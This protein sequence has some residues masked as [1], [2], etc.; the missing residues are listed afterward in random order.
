MTLLMDIITIAAVFIL[1][2]IIF[3]Y[4]VFPYIIL[5]WI[6]VR[7]GA[8]FT[9]MT[10]KYYSEA[11]QFADDFEDI[12]NLEQP[13]YYFNFDEETMTYFRSEDK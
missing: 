7:L 8:Y 11:V 10:L 2:W 13:L 4:I 9:E 6:T 5:P 1:V 12:V 3:R